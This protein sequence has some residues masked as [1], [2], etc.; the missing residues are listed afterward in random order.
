MSAES[1]RLQV[2]AEEGRSIDVDQGKRTPLAIRV[3]RSLL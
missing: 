3:K 2:R 1:C